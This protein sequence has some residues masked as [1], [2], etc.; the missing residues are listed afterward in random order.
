M[1]NFQNEPMQKISTQVQTTKDYYLFTPIDGNRNKNLLHLNRLKKSINENYL[2]T[3]IIVNENY[4]IIDGQHRFDVIK[5]LNLPLH[6][7]VCVGYGLKE[8]H[9]LNQISKTWNA[10][11][12]LNGYCN[13]GYKDYIKYKEFKE[14]YGLG[15]N[16]CMTILAGRFIKTPVD[17]FYNGLFKI[18]DYNESCKIVEKIFLVEPYYEGFRRRSFIYALLQ[19]TTYCNGRLCKSISVR[20]FN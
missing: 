14:I 19:N 16:E 3:V 5:E 2:F 7:I 17:E 4:Q 12:Y 18:K 1:I 10:D 11:D 13:L 6:Y 9:I 8:V 15:H 20:I